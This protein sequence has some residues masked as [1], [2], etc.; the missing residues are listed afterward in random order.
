LDDTTYQNCPDEL[1]GGW[2]NT[3]Q[4][5][6]LIRTNAPWRSFW[7]ASKREKSMAALAKFVRDNNAQVLVGQD[8]TC[9]EKDD[10]LQWE[11]N[12]K[13]MKQLGIEHILGV[14][15]GNEMDILYQHPDWWRKDFPNCMVDLW[16]KK[17]Y[18]KAFQRRV[19]EM[20]KALGPNAKNIL[21]T[22]VW[23]AGFAHSGTGFNPPFAEFPGRAMVRTFVQDAYK[24]YGKRWVWTFNP[25]PIWASGLQPDAG[26][27]DQCNKAIALTKGPIAHDMIA[28]TR[29]AIKWVTQGDDDLLWAGEYGWSSP[30]SDGMGGSIFRCKNYTSLQTFTGYYE[31]FLQ[32][33][34]T[35]SEATKPEDRTLRG[36]D[37]A[38]FFAMRDADN[39]AAQEHFGLVKK[40][41]DTKCKII[42]PIAESPSITV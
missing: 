30:A 12:L 26:H 10:D 40:C 21:L 33:D 2:P 42:N 17:K 15:I 41:G 38:F 5:V 28:Y 1:L 19:S 14:A 8:A 35:L 20:D 36:V 3:K 7:D 37:R 11:L 22:S 13:F 23:T 6:K 4:Q 24:A 32:W 9:N 16:D 25:Y 31:H 27:A 39:G 18:W 34:L 29:R